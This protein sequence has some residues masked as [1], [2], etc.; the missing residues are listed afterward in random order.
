ML[1][2]MNSA[3]VLRKRSRYIRRLHEILNGRIIEISFPKFII[4]NQEEIMLTS[5]ATLHTGCREI[6]VNNTRKITLIC[7]AFYFSME[8]NM[9]MTSLN[10]HKALKNGMFLVCCIIFLFVPLNIHALTTYT[11]TAQFPELGLMETAIA[12]TVFPSA[13]WESKTPADAGMDAAKLDEFRNKLGLASYGVVIKDGYLVY[14]WGNQTQHGEWASATKPLFGTLLGFAIQEGLIASPDVLILDFGWPL[15]PKDQ[16]MTFRHLAN[17][18]SGYSLPEAPGESWAYNDYAIQ[19][20][21]KTLYEKLYGISASSV[22]AV[23]AHVTNSSRLGPLQFQDG[24]LFVSKK[25][26]TRIKWIWMGRKMDMI[27]N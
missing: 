12:D 19:L 23:T 14:Q 16:T 15:I 5:P 1:L 21:S 13:T 22:S 6:T 26:G 17:M 18:V 7:S 8:S 9:K 20:Y 10:L 27:L 25:G 11:L 2:P 24:S 3:T 4:R